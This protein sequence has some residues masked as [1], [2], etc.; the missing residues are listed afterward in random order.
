[1]N[2]IEDIMCRVKT[3]IEAIIGTA[4]VQDCE[5]LGGGVLDSLSTI[6]LIT[7]LEVQFGI[8]LSTEDFTHYNFNSI[9]AICQL[10]LSKRQSGEAASK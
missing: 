1:M 6:E 9:H 10:V 8:S 4:L 2:T 3:M 7:S 5:L